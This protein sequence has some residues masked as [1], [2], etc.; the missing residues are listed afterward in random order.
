MLPVVY[1]EPVSTTPVVRLDALQ[2]YD[3]YTQG[4]ARIGYNDGDK[5]LGGFGETELLIT[6]YWTL[7]ARST[8]LFTKNLYARGLIR[9]LVTNEINI[10]LFPDVIPEEEL[11]EASEGDLQ[12]W[13]DQVE[14]RFE[15]WGKNPKLCDHKRENTFGALMRAARLEALVGGDCLIVMRQSPVT[16][17]PNIQIVPGSKVQT[18]LGGKTDIRKGHT[19]QHGVE[20]DT[21]GR[22][23]AYW[24]R[25]D[26]NTTKRQPTMGEKSGRKLAWLVF[27]TDKRHED[28]RGEPLLSIVLQSLK[29]IDRYRDSTQRKAVINSMLA[30]FIKKT[31]DKVGSLPMTNGALRKDAVTTTDSDGT[32]RSFGITNNMPGMVMEELQQGEEPVAFGSQGTDTDFGTFEGAMIQAIAW[33]NELPPEILTLAFSNNYSASQAAIN[34]FKVYLRKVWSSWGETF[35]TPIYIE[36]LL[37]ENLQG[38]I[39][40]PGLLAAWRDPLQY[41]TFGAWTQVVWYG[42]VKPS[43]DMVKQ[44]KAS[45]M[46][47][48]EGWSTNAREAREINGSKFSRNMKILKRENE[49]KADAMRPLLEVEKEFGTV[50]TQGT[51][52]AV[53]ALD[54]AVEAIEALTHEQSE[55]IS[56]PSVG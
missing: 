31:Q 56:N 21:R 46:L 40:T 30:M 29:E 2:G 52:Q 10:G 8:Q 3:P 36:W 38:K 26:D 35:C 22:V 49:Q 37:A 41:D 50:E 18:P 20:K 45:K 5:F 19:V 17:L 1:S 23:V 27:G 48:D 24:I 42:T 55:N 9:R 11:L 39:N 16:K 43:T 13:S 53:A 15:I 7:R 33:A 6:D 54:N 51:T 28:V 32:T 44:G 12:E 25:Q 4:A 34:E 14:A 47:T